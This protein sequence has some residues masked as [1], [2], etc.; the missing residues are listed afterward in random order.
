MV[1]DQV[2]RI[3]RPNRDDF[4]NNYVLP[5]KPVVISGAVNE[6]R[7]ISS[8]SIDHFKSI[9]GNSEIRVEI[10]PTNYFPPVHDKPFNLSSFVLR[11]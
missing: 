11:K 7:A 4:Y 1:T 5:G 2:E 9:A 3:E 8:W 10:S 6:W